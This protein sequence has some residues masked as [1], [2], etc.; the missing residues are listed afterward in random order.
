MNK[1]RLLYLIIVLSAGY[2]LWINGGKLISSFEYIEYRGERIKLSRAYYNYD[3]YKHDPDNLDPLEISRIEQLMTSA[4]LRGTY[5]SQA[6]M[7]R[8][9]FGLQFP[10]YGMSQ[11]GEKPQSDGSVIAGYSL[12]IPLANKDRYL[13]FRST[14]DTYTLIDDFIESSDTPIWRVRE[15]KGNL[16]YSTSQDKIVRTRPIVEIK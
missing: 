7:V 3:A 2:L 16:V 8:E 14:S 11:I 13:I 12:E 10:G 9:V 1:R 6:Q 15:E 5:T 4:T